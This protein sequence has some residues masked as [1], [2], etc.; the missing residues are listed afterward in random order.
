MAHWSLG[1]G[2]GRVLSCGVEYLARPQEGVHRC[3]THTP[4]HA[5]SN[6]VWETL[7]EWHQLTCAYPRDESSGGL[8][9]PLLAHLLLERPLVVRAIKDLFLAIRILKNWDT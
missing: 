1:E 7:T 4:M 5:L 2:A 3:T 9:L 6:I 8:L